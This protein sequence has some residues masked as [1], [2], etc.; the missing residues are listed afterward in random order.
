MMR[1]LVLLFALLSMPVLAAADMPWSDADAESVGNVLLAQAP[2][3]SQPQGGQQQTG[4]QRYPGDYCTRHCRPN[5]TPCGDEC[6][7]PKGGVTPKCTKKVTTTCP[8][9]P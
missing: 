9:K 7:A 3:Q 1:V 6:L 2:P 4:P 5:E 8:G